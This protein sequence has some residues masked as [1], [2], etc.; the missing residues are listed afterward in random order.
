MR[1][2][3]NAGNGTALWQLAATLDMIATEGPPRPGSRAALAALAL[4][5]LADPQLLGPLADQAL[6]GAGDVAVVAAKLVVRAGL[7]GAY[8]AYAAR[9]KSGSSAARKSFIAILK[10]LGVVSLPMFRAALERLEANVARPGVPQVVEDLLEGLPHVSDEATGAVLARYARGENAGLAR[11]AAAALARVW[12][13]RARAIL[14]G[15]L[16]H[17]DPSVQAAAIDALAALGAVDEHLVRKLDAIVNGPVSSSRRLR[18]AAAS[19]LARA[20]P[21]ARKDAGTA[22]VRA[23]SAPHATGA[24]DDDVVVEVAR[25]LLAIGGARARDEVAKMAQASAPGLRAQLQQVLVRV[26]PG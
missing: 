1:R 3:A 15:L 20:T 8:A 5:P 18:V 14:V 6:T 17:E 10:Q 7:G 2:L 12:G 19:A 23:F 13:E 9:E 21:E 26:E 4:K 25:S 11:L 22:L 16:Q 24:Q